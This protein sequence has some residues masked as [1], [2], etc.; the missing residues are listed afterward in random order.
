MAA[1]P[2]RDAIRFTDV[3]SMSGCPHDSERL[4]AAIMANVKLASKCLE[5]AKSCEKTMDTDP[6]KPALRNDSNRTEAKKLDPAANETNAVNGNNGLRP[7][8]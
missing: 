3:E 1:L 7:L 8:E 5:S 4:D 6:G 2:D